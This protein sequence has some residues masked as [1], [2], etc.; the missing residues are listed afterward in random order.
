MNVKKRTMKKRMNRQDAHRTNPECGMKAM[1]PFTVSS[2]TSEKIQGTNYTIA[3]WIRAPRQREA[4]QVLI[5]RQARWYYR[6]FIQKDFGLLH[7]A[8]PNIGDYGCG[9]VDTGKWT[10][11]AV[12]GDD[13]MLH[14]YMDGILIYTFDVPGGIPGEGSDSD[15]AVGAMPDGTEP[16]KG[17]IEEVYL[18]NRTSS[19]EEVRALMNKTRRR[20]PPIHRANLIP[21]APLHEDPLFNCSKDGTLVWNYREDNWWYLYMQIRNG[22]QER[23]VSIH[24]GTTIGA[25]SSSDG[26]LTWDYRGTLNGLEFEPG[27]RKGQNTLWAPDVVWHEGKYKAV[28]SYVRGRNPN[29]EGDR[30]LMIY[31]SSNLLDWKME[32][33][34]VNVGSNRC[35]DAT[36][37]RKPNGKWGLWFKDEVIGLT[38]VAESADLC[39]FRLIGY[40]DPS[41]MAMEGADVFFW[42]GYY[43]LIGDDC[44]SYD[45]LRV[46][47]SNDCENWERKHNILNKPGRRTQDQGVGHHPEVI[48]NGEDAYI[49]YWVGNTGPLMYEG[50]QIGYLQVAKLG[51]REEQLTCDRDEEFELKLPR[52]PGDG[53]TS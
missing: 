12:V 13:Y 10:H 5:S 18:L 35:L 2:V 42:K 31:T 1:N 3:V 29:W 38:G 44:Y 20:D 46:Y 48:V 45:G 6:L 26:G 23:N 7:F 39:A 34:I 30:R 11:V 49:F 51:F 33:P 25:A 21:P 24:H 22:F 41:A 28:I 43:W 40:M 16:C 15:V 27:A 17:E 36:S 14:F 8:C 9:V 32:C 53:Q 50:S 19:A 52:G 47:R 37:Y 4:N